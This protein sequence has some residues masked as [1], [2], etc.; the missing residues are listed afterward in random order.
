MYV[1][2]CMYVRMNVCIMCVCT[3]ACMYAVSAVSFKV[4]ISHT[5][6]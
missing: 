3:C 4:C 2:V 6:M 1:C 5:N